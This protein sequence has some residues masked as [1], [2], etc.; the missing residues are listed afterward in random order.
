[1]KI[2]TNSSHS[3]SKNIFIPLLNNFTLFPQDTIL[4]TV[5]P[6]LLIMVVNSLSIYRYRQCMK[7]YS[8]GVLRVRFL[9]VPDQP[10]NEPKNTEET[11]TAK[12]LL[13]SSTTAAQP[14]Q[15]AL[16]TMPGA[17]G[18]TGAARGPNGGKLKSSDLTLSR[19]LLIVTR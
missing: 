1:L 4:C 2:I 10:D 3:P 5:V 14:T 7:V 18:A 9:R 11:S 17:T 13:F 15:T 16:S 12:K 19:S 8:S 6:S